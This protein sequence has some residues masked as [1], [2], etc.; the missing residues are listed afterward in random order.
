MTAMRLA[1]FATP[2]LLGD[3]RPA[4]GALDGDVFRARLAQVREDVAVPARELKGILDHAAV[5]EVL[6]GENLNAGID[7]PVGRAIGWRFSRVAHHCRRRR[8]ERE[9]HSA[10]C[11]FA[12]DGAYQV[13]NAPGG[14]IPS[15]DGHDDFAT[16]I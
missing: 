6:H 11:T 1:I 13:A 4:P 3:M 15:L 2:K 5:E 12:L 8:S 10:L 14:E 9:Q 16:A 7:L